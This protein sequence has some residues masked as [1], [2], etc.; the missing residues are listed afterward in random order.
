[1][2]AIFARGLAL[3]IAM[4]GLSA[5]LGWAVLLTCLAVGYAPPAAI[6]VGPLALLNSIGAVSLWRRA[7][8]PRRQT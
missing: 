7:Q 1:M 6:A 4:L 8:T 3:P 5:A 2:D